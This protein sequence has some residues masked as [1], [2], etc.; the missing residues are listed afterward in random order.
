M[1][2]TLIN[3]VLVVIFIFSVPVVAAAQSLCEGLTTM[4]TADKDDLD[5]FMAPG[6]TECR[7]KGGTSI[8]QSDNIIACSWQKASVSAFQISKARKMLMPDVKK[9]ASAVKQCITQKKILPYTLLESGSMRGD[10]GEGFYFEVTRDGYRYKGVIA[11]CF[12]YARYDDG[13]AVIVLAVDQGVYLDP[14]THRYGKFCID[15][16]DF[17]ID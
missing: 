5:L 7:T 11:V 16:I 13:K 3:I 10:E 15:G 6:A 8:A 1:K 4:L 9:L 12:Q 17:K 14:D 2:T